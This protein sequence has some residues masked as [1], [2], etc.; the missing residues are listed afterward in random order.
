MNILLFDAALVKQN[1]YVCLTLNAAA[2]ADQNVALLL[3]A[4]LFS[5]VCGTSRS[6]V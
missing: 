2:R 3:A 5:N 6:E 1:I 4:G